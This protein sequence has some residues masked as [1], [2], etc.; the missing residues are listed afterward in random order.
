[1]DGGTAPGMATTIRP[2]LQG[3]HNPNEMHP[4][5]GWS[6]IRSLPWAVPT[7]IE[8]VP[9]GDEI[10]RG[11]SFDTPSDATR[12]WVRTFRG[13]QPAAKF[14]RHSRGCVKT[15]AAAFLFSSPAVYGWVSDRSN[16]KPDSSGFQA[17]LSSS[18]RGSPMNRA[19]MLCRIP[20]SRERLG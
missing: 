7:A 6:S 19:Q 2:T 8:F 1:M 11:L 12:A 9:F 13:L 17:C 20:P 3:L 16:C 18:E 14:T 4:L 5:Q 10:G 15:V